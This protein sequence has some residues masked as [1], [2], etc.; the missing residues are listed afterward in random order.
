MSQRRHLLSTPS[1][2]VARTIE[3]HSGEHDTGSMMFRPHGWPRPSARAGVWGTIL[4]V[5]HATSIMTS[6]LSLQ[7]NPLW[8]LTGGRHKEATRGCQTKTTT[9]PRVIGNN[10]RPLRARTYECS[11]SQSFKCAKIRLGKARRSS[12]SGGT[13]HSLVRNQSF[14][15]F[16]PLSLVI[17]AL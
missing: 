4:A 8:H 9:A 14:D 12:R 2:A 7:I 3:A 1:H 11:D 17:L 16:I 10:F 15:I 5:N 13:G 6:G